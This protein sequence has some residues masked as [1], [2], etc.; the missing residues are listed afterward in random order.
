MLPLACLI[1]A[2]LGFVIAWRVRG[3]LVRKQV[4]ALWK[5]RLEEH[6]RDLH[7]KRQLLAE[8][9]KALAKAKLTAADVSALSK[10]LAEREAALA[11]ANEKVM[12]LE[13][14]LSG[15]K[16]SGQALRDKLGRLQGGL[17]ALVARHIEERREHRR[18][19][20]GERALLEKMVAETRGA[21][22]K[23]RA[24]SEELLREHAAR[25]ADKD[26]LQP[27]PAP[28]PADQQEHERFKALLSG[29]E[30]TVGDLRRQLDAR[31]AEQQQRPATG[32][33]TD[34]LGE[35]TST[36]EIAPG[37]P[38]SRRRRSRR[39]KGQDPG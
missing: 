31:A 12:A 27:A 39:K 4:D 38:G 5:P 32:G 17:R 8:A 25:A 26:H 15:E 2:L 20:A 1:V 37:E 10:S 28:P 22:A 14:E 3:R 36:G 33:D 23:E 24:R 7:E 30:S 35:G 16:S 6:I 19:A 11:A 29:L 21:L 9:E 34:K 18:V 13:K